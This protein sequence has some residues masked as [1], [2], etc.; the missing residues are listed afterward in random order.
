MTIE[1]RLAGEIPVAVLVGRITLGEPARSLRAYFTEMSTDGHKSVLLDLSGVSFVDSSGLGALVSGY[2]SMK[3][4]GG[5]VA[6][7]AVPGR[8]R[9]LLELSR[10]TSVFP[11]YASEA[12][13]A[14]KRVA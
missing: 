8:I 11:I 6:L 12:E 5:S 13:M 7:V 10:L 4:R 2:N 9:E 1:R 3:K 14:S